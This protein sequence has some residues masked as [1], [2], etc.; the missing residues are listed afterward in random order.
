MKTKCAIMTSKRYPL[1]GFKENKIIPKVKENG[2]EDMANYDK[3]T[4]F[5]NT[6][7]KETKMILMRTMHQ[8]YQSYALS[9]VVK[10]HMI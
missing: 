10:V 2:L 3:K 1:K 8:W 7:H 6:Y 5:P 4:M 9:I